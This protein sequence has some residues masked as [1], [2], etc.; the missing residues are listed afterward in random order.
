MATAP[1]TGKLLQRAARWER[2]NAILAAA[3][4]LLAG[5][6]CGSSSQL[7]PPRAGAVHG[8]ADTLAVDT[9][10]GDAIPGSGGGSEAGAQDPADGD[11]GAHDAAAQES[12]ATDLATQEAAENDASPCPAALVTQ[13]SVA[14]PDA[15]TML[16][17]QADAVGSALLDELFGRFLRG[18]VR[19]YRGSF[20]GS[21]RIVSDEN[22]PPGTTDVPISDGPAVAML[23]VRPASPADWYPRDPAPSGSAGILI[24]HSLAAHRYGIYMQS[25]NDPST[26]WVGAFG[27]DAPAETNNM[28][29]SCVGCAPAFTTWPVALSIDALDAKGL[30]HAYQAASGY[31]DV[32]VSTT[33]TATLE[34]APPCTLT[35]DDLAVLD[36]VTGTDSF[37]SDPGL[38]SFRPQGDEMVSQRSGSSGRPPAGECAL[39]TSWTLDVWVKRDLSAMGTR[40]FQASTPTMMCTP[41]I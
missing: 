35:W 22:T 37:A 18:D 20:S 4:F 27:S 30:F 19:V 23:A 16:Q 41:T 34:T 6:G 40:N 2:D 25:V 15:G 31:V 21:S 39:V 24:I 29:R 10:G 11:A 14:S 12:G 32:P 1:S 13:A 38:T 9:G 7:A 26:T 3:C 33:T 8:D 36:T 28:D 17:A 5:W